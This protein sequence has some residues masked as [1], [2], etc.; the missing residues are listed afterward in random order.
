MEIEEIEEINHKDICGYLSNIGLEPVRET[1]RSYQYYSPFRKETVASFHVWKKDNK[2]KD[3]GNGKWG[4]I[5]DLV[6]ELKGCSFMIAVG[7]LRCGQTVPLQEFTVPEKLLK[8][9]IEIVSENDIHSQSLIDYVEGR[10]INIDLARRHLSQVEFRFPHG[11]APGRI[12]SAVG[13]KNDSEGYELRSNFWKVS[14]SPK[15]IKTIKGTEK[16]FMVYEGF[17]DLLSAYVYFKKEYF[18][19]TIIVLNSLSFI[20]SLVPILKDANLTY[21][22]IDNGKAANERID[23]LREEGV[24]FED[25]RHY[26]EGHGDFNEFLVAKNCGSLK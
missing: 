14:N 25:C 26:F 13:F 11:K 24:V 19:S 15:T 3:F 10:G 12:H 20:N 21:L 9:G 7:M 16:T 1:V 18:K 2:W 23:M 6:M 5:I 22:F 17:F 4:S 8:K